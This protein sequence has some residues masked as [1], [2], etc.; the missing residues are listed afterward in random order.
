LTGKFHVCKYLAIYFLA[1]TL[2][3]ETDKSMIPAMTAE[4]WIRIRIKMLRYG[5]TFDSIAQRHGVTRQRV[6][7]IIKRGY[8]AKNRA[9]DVLDDFYGRLSGI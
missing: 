4:E 2:T 6:H 1:N 3:S 7:Q 8:P 5:V 9:K